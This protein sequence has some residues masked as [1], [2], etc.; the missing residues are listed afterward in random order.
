MKKINL[1]APVANLKAQSFLRMY[2]AIAPNWVNPAADGNKEWRWKNGKNGISSG[3]AGY[4]IKILKR[5]KT[6]GVDRLKT[7]YFIGPNNVPIW[8]SFE[9]DVNIPINCPF[10]DLAVC[11]NRVVDDA[12]AYSS[13]RCPPEILLSSLR[14]Y[15]AQIAK[16][17]KE[18]SKWGMNQAEINLCLKTIMINT[19]IQKKGTE[20]KE[21]SISDIWICDSIDKLNENN[22]FKKLISGQVTG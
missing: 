3:S 6:E 8:K 19:M 2:K 21:D 10:S 4:T 20:P 12:T 17:D 18:L 9:G 5:R 7:L 14:S 15:T 16:M 1:K 11:I 22:H 13:H